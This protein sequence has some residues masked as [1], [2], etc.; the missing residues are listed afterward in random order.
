MAQHHPDHTV[1][2]FEAE[3]ADPTKS[4]TPD[5]DTKIGTGP[6]SEARSLYEIRPGSSGHRDK[7]V[8]LVCGHETRRSGHMTDH[9]NRE[10]LKNPLRCVFCD[11]TTLNMAT[12][13]SHV[14]A[15]HD[16]RRKKCNFPGCH[17]TAKE[18]GKLQKHLAG[19]CQKKAE[20]VKL[21]T[22]PWCDMT[23]DSYVS[24]HPPSRQDKA[25]AEPEKLHLVR[26]QIHRP[27]QGGIQEHLQKVH[28]AVYDP[29][30]HS[31][32]FTI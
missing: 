6:A 19:H 22:C 18:E 26:M 25:W 16:K 24:I 14:D 27:L 29:S 3:L 7:C 17:F 1:T 8:C 10:H 32:K 30:D 4:Y 11:Y 15:T 21:H 2:H 20:D 23:F 12:L 9:I 31:L 5:P 13:Q 28:G